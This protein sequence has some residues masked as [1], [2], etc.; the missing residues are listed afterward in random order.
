MPV[1]VDRQNL[2]AIALR[3][4]GLVGKGLVVMVGVKVDLCSGAHPEDDDRTVR[5]EPQMAVAR[6][7]TARHCLDRDGVRSIDD[8]AGEAWRVLTKQ[9]GANRRANAIRTDHHVRLEFTT[10]SKASAR[11]VAHGAHR[12]AALSDADEP[13]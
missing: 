11:D 13:R 12:F 5:T 3:H 6:R 2:L 4:P 7:S 10:A 1:L 9:A 8:L